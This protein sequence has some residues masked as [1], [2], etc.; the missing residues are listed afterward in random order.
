MCCVHLESLATT[1]LNG[2]TSLLFTSSIV[3]RTAPCFFLVGCWAGSGCDVVGLSL[4]LMSATV[5]F[6][7]VFAWSLTNIANETSSTRLQAIERRRKS[8]DIGTT[9]H[10]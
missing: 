7:P 5:C 8:E 2:E 1:P 6:S 4:L 3:L 10:R 9:P